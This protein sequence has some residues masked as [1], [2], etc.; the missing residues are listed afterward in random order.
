METGHT[1]STIQTAIKKKNR[2]A[3][4]QSKLPLTAFPCRCGGYYCSLHR[5]DVEHTCRYDY[6]AE[7]TKL[8]STNLVKVVG[9][10]LE[11]V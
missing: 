3:C 2:C 8:L 6:R 5:A 1:M 10:K 7:S 9:P 11:I 4:C